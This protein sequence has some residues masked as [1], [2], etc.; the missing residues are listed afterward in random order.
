MKSVVAALAATLLTLSSAV[1]DKPIRALSVED[2]VARHVAGDWVSEGA[3]PD[4]AGMVP[5]LQL[6]AGADY[7]MFAAHP[8]HY[9]SRRAD[10][11]GT[12]KAH[13]AIDGSLEIGLV[14][15]ETQRGLWRVYR[16]MRDGSLQQGGE[17]LVWRRLTAKVP[18]GADQL[19]NTAINS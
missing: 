13:E 15:S 14:E 3:V 12:W 2:A 11:G 16:W 19:A 10:S 5:L 17:A 6:S 7:T 8:S 18:I 4:M 1:A 9:A